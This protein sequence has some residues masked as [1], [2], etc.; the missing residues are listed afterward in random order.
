M[1]DA[2]QYGFSLLILWIRS[3]RLWS[4]FGRPTLFRDFQRQNALKPA[5]CHLRTV[6]GLTTWMLQSRARP[7]PRHPNQQRAVAT[8]ETNTRWGTPQGD[9]ELMSEQQVLGFQ[10]EPRLEQ[11]EDEHSEGV[12]DRQH[13][14]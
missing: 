9:A 6:S 8:E 2:P 3:R 13:R 5:R 14:H 12:Q 11:V 4:I 7:E 1:R 10:P